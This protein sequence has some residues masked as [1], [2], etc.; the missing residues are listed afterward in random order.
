[1]DP[2]FADLLEI[3]SHIRNCETTPL[4]GSMTPVGYEEFM[5][6]V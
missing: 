2:Q 1:M 3:L 5:I 4:F 6:P